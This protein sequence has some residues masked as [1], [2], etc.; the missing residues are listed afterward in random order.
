MK[1]I[2]GFVMLSVLLI[3][4]ACDSKC[5]GYTIRGTAEGT[6][7]G[8]T[9]FLCTMKGFFSFVPFD[10]AIVRNGEFEFRGKADEVS[11]CIVL[12]TH[13]GTNDGLGIVDVPFENSLIE[14]QIFAPETKK[15]P[16]VV[17]H[18][19][20]G[21][22]WDEHQKLQSDWEA[23]QDAPWQ[24]VLNQSGTPEE[25][26]Q[27][28]KELDSITA[29]MAEAERLFIVDHA[30]TGIADYLFAEYYRNPANEATKDILLKAYSAKNPD[31]PHYRKIL[32]QIEVQKNADEGGLF[33]DFTMGDTDGK[34]V[35]VMSIIK[36]NQYTLVDFW[37]SWCGPCRAEM[38]NVVAAYHKYHDKGFQVIGVSLD[39][40]KQEWLAAIE[41]LQ[42]PWPQLSD[43]KG[44]EC[45]GA[46]LY[47]IQSIPSNLLVNQQGK[48]VARDLREEALQ[49]KLSVLFN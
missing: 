14:V 45:E 7:E 37:A 38:P 9:V 6:V 12:P 5:D 47:K 27:A 1:R 43:L 16:I 41:K 23:R 21:P 44:W 18:G 36:E 26:E 35:S 17:N 13:A 28:Q 10:T 19:P 11:V 48:I 49:D 22:L 31:G 24:I 8:D 32:K 30:G 15:A 2:V 46:V 34:P 39:G 20:D 42:M 4:A 3:C 25:I 29:E 33:T 40:D